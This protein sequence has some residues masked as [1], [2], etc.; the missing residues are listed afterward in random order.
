MK[1]DDDR[2]L[3]RYGVLY[4]GLRLADLVEVCGGQLGEEDRVAWG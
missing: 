2:T 1:G 4:C 3:I